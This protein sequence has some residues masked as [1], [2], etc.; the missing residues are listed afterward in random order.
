MKNDLKM[1]ISF[2][3]V[4][5]V[6]QTLPLYSF[7]NVLNSNEPGKEIIFK[8]VIDRDGLK[9][10]VKKF[11]DNQSTVTHLTFSEVNSKLLMI[12]CQYQIAD[13]KKYDKMI[14][15]FATSLIKLD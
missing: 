11:V 4:I 8:E 6:P 12:K 7:E 10:G 3:T 14:L 2:D 5:Q 9:I 13:D 15:E 1:T